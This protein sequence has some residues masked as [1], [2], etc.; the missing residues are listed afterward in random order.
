MSELVV[1][2]WACIVVVAGWVSRPPTDRR[3]ASRAAGAML[4]L[5]VRSGALPRRN[6]SR[7]HRRRETSELGHL[8]G[9]VDLLVVALT[10]G[11]SVGAA[12]ET[13]ADHLPESQDAGVAATSAALR[14]GVPLESALRSWGESRSEAAPIAAMLVGGGRSGAAL[15]TDLSRFA[16]GLRR[17]QRRAAEERARRLPVLMLVPLV[18]CVLPAFCLLT[19]V[20]MLAAGLSRLGS[21]V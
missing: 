11:A 13:V 8:A 3:Q 15:T 14:R 21:V 20:P 1:A 19:V 18:C 9:T 10:A 16:D 5:A 7:G 12:L 2:L 17:R 4:A 6:R